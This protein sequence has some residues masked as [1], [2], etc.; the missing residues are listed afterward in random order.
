MARTSTSATLGSD[1]YTNVRNAILSGQLQPG[2]HLKASE[3]RHTFGPVSSS[4]VREAL[5]RLTAQRLVVAKHNQGF[6][7]TDVTVEGIR[8]LTKVRVLVEGNALRLA[9]ENGGFDW[10]SRV[11]AAHHVLARTPVRGHSGEG[12][13]EAWAAA[14]REFHES[15]ISACGI[16]VLLDICDLLLDGSELYRRVASRVGDPGRDVARE[17]RELMELTIDKRADEAVE[18]FRRHIE[19]TAETVVRALE[20]RA[21]SGAGAEIDLSM[22]S[23][24]PAPT[25]DDH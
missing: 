14:H 1:V 19:R 13:S 21:M 16:P 17:H 2:A 7:V 10:E 3:L 24:L 5:S 12:T 25:E 23:R 11:V 22:A 6:F 4:V 8:G 9:I 20:E 15:L 18:S